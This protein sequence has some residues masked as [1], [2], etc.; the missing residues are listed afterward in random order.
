MERLTAQCSSL[1][2]DILKAK[3]NLKETFIRI[4]NYNVFLMCTVATYLAIVFP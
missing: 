3:S 2:I 1:D 4:C